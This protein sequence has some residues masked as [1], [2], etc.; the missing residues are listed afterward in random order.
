MKSKSVVLNEF[1]QLLG[2]KYAEN[3]VDS[4]VNY[5]SDFLDF[6]SHAPLRVTN[7]DFLNFNI[8]L[9][10]SDISDSTRNVAISGVK[11]YF[12]LYLKKRLD[13]NVTIRPKKKK[14]VLRQID[15]KFLMQKIDITK[16]LKAKIILML[17]YG[18]GLRT[19]EVINLKLDD[20]DI[21]QRFIVINGKGSKQRT[22]PLSDRLIFFLISYVEYY[23]PIKY[24][25]NGKT[26]KNKFSYQYSASSILKIVKHN[27]GNYRFHDLRHSFGML[28]YQKKLSLERIAKL[29]GH[30]D[31]KTT[32]I[33]AYSTDNMMLETKLPLEYC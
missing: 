15:H 21:E 1:K 29:L 33:Y 30:S 9:S 7:D 26:I 19:N 4:Y 3:S 11:H 28:L 23:K 18:C 31:T 17:G 5:V 8:Y 24:L 27:I 32:E 12:K 2:L 6:S 10:Q 16:N 25:I 14:K 20:I 13:K 22:L